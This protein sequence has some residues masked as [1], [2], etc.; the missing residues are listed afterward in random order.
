[1]HK[2]FDCMA[3]RR[4]LFDRC[5]SGFTSI[6]LSIS[7]LRSDERLRQVLPLQ[8]HTTEGTTYRLRRRERGR[9]EGRYRPV[10]ANDFANAGRTDEEEE[11]EE[12]V[13]IRM[14]PVRRF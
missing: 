12:E 5:I 4:S 10:K 3:R 1:M 13:R 6:K 11:E 7:L 14:I 8:T 2:R 9:A